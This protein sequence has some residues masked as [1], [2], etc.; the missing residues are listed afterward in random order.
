M[1]P[2]VFKPH[3]VSNY[4]GA[5][6]Y[7][8]AGLR[9]RI[10]W[11]GLN[12]EHQAFYRSPDDPRLLGTVVNG[13]EPVS[14]EILAFFQRKQD[15]LFEIMQDADRFYLTSLTTAKWYPH[16]GWVRCEP[17]ANDSPALS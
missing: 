10:T 2:A 3:F 8:W 11:R 16:L 1:S 4:Q 12:R 7:R 14:A 15:E 5:S 9:G 17:T 6:D 13:S